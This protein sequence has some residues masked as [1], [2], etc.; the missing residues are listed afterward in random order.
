[1]FLRIFQHLLPDARAWRIIVDKMLRDFFIGLTGAPEDARD[2]VDDVYAERDPQ[3]TTQLDEWEK[4]FAIVQNP[5][6]T[7]A[8]RRQQLDAAW[9]ARGGQ[10]PSYIEG[11][12]Q[13]NG[14]PIYIH[15]WWE[16]PFT[17]NELLV[18]GNFEAGGPPPVAP[19][20]WTAGSLAALSTVAGTLTG[21]DGTQYLRVTVGTTDAYGYAF[22]VATTPGRT[23]RATGTT[24]GD[25]INGFPRVEDPVSGILW[26]G[27]TST[28]PQKFSVEYTAAGTSLLLACSGNVATIDHADFDEVSVR[29]V[30]V[31]RD[32]RDYTVDPL[33]G[34]IQCDNLLA[35]QT[36]CSDLATQD[37]C[38]D[39][40]A[41]NP[42]YLV[43]DNL[44][45]RA[46]PPIP[47][48]STKWPFFI[49]F[50]PETLTTTDLVLIPNSRRAEFERRVLQLCPMHCWIV[51][52]SDYTTSGVF[53]PS[54]DDSFE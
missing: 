21:G 3:T 13:A 14:F 42:R 20:S 34:T 25:G 5:A 2:F 16:L 1:V 11:V 52:M 38:N 17:P 48:D 27:T 9:Q 32:P 51:V 50:G 7:D 44:S 35:S 18:N 19:T 30:Y 41:N 45:L 12:L 6:D 49:Y 43:N 47:D 53:G 24:R 40:L 10:S 36:Q 15:D 37:Q 22:Q 29:E 4:Q 23:Y 39:F 26:T 33:I 31:A 46:P 54:F 8:I 28:T